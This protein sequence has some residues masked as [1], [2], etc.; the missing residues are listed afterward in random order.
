HGVALPSLP[1]GPLKGTRCSGDLMLVSCASPSPASTATRKDK[2]ADGV[3]GGGGGASKA[4]DGC[5]STLGSD[6]GR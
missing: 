4:D 3:V 1:T 5:V 6:D 2:T